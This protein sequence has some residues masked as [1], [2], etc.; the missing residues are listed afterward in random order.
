[1]DWS[2]YLPTIIPLATAIV[3]V[4]GGYLLSSSAAGWLRRRGA[5]AAAVRWVRF[6][7][8]IVGLLLA[9][10]VLFV[11]FG[12]LTVASGV[13]LSAIVGLA[14]TLALQTVIGN[15]I[16][17]VILLRD[18]LL[19]LGDHIQ[20]GGVSGAVVRLGLVT[21]WLRTDDG[22]FAAVSNSNL[23]SGP[24]VNKTAKDRLKDEV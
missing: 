16:A 14:A 9:S 21:T 15:V 7:I 18:R 19:R 10:A 8:A 12:P 20:V 17:G 11:A 2:S 23:L 5:P 1:V 6:S 4:V 24:L 22:S 3:L 13:T